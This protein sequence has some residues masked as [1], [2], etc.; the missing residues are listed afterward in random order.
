MLLVSRQGLAY[1][2]QLHELSLCLWETLALEITYVVDVI[3]HCHCVRIVVILS[4][5]YCI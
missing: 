1:K 3:T 5:L 4:S 2:P